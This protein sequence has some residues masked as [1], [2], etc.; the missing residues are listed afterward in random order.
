MAKKNCSIDGCDR[1]ASARGWCPAHY[2]RWQRHGDPLGGNPTP[3]GPRRFFDDALRSDTND[4]LIW[5]F[6][7][8]G[9]GY[10][11]MW[12]EGSMRAVHRLVCEQHHGAPPSPSHEAAHSCGHGDL[13]CIAPNHLRWATPKENQEDR[14]K[15]GTS[16]RGERHLSAKLTEADV[17]MIRRLDGH[18]PR[19]ELAAR[20]NVT[21]SGIKQVIRRASWAWLP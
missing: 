7:R 3:G 14:I 5:A 13:G 15:H 18:V 16:L 12:H 21:P 20:F 10:A 2:V 8:G 9:N 6:G 19:N 17:H 4:C 1:P 11:M